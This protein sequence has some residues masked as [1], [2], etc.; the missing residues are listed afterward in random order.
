MRAMIL[1]AGLGTRLHPL[2]SVRPKVL[3]PLLGVSM[4]RFW[5]ERLHACGFEDVVLNAYHRKE[6]LA[7][8]V[9]RGDWPIP[10]E[11]LPESVLLGTGGG[12]RNALDSF[13]DETFV[14]INGDIVCDA[15]LA[16]L[17][18]EHRRSGAAVSLLMHD[19]PEFNNVAVGKDGAVLGFGREAEK[20]AAAGNGFRKMAFTGIHFINPAALADARKGVPGDILTVYRGLI[21]KGFPPVSLTCPNMFWR[22][23]GS[24]ASYRALSAELTRL[25]SGFL[26]PLPTGEAVLL[27]PEAVV[28]KDVGLSGVVVAGRGARIG[29][30]ARLENVIM[31]ENVRIGPGSRLNDCIVA[32]G[33]RVCG[34]HSGRVI[35]PEAG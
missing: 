20:M 18:E 2:T 9:S 1:A 7:D 19:F 31:W 23:M 26:P 14:V 4:L 12:I 13:G 15:P 8:A 27:H 35:V 5:V 34:D 30:G 33:M 3:V 29:A 10:V 24:I 21:A 11:V 16:E 32:D 25:E 6:H 17:A 22:E 28:E